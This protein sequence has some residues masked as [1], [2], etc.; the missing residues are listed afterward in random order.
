[1]GQT[2]TTTLFQDDLMTIATETIPPGVYFC[3][4]K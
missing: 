3:R 2:I 4:I 1:M